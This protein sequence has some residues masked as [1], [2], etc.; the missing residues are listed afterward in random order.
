[1]AGRTLDELIAKGRATV[2]NSVADSTKAQYTRC[3]SE[4][5]RFCEQYGLEKLAASPMQVNKI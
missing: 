3:W 4:Y 2:S 1:M 5:E